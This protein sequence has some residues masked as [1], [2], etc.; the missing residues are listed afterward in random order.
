MNIQLDPFGQGIQQAS[1]LIF[2]A[3]FAIPEA[4]DTIAHL[5]PLAAQD[6]SLIPEHVVG[7]TIGA[8]D[9]AGLLDFKKDTGM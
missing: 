4:P 6:A 8:F 9:L 5:M 7:T 3:R 1:G 2:M